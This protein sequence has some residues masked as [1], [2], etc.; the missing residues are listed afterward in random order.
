MTGE[1]TSAMM[2]MP[3]S[4]TCLLGEWAERD[5]LYLRGQRT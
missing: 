5:V 3:G 1:T 2:E 4:C